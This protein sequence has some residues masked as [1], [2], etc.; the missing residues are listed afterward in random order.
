VNGHIHPLSPPPYV[1][2]DF[3][4]GAPQQ[5]SHK[6]RCSRS[7]ALHLSFGFPNK[8]ALPEA[9]SMEP[10]E[11]AIPHPQSPFIQLSKVPSRR[12][13]L[14]V[15]QK[16]S[17]YE[18]RC[19]SPEPFLNILRGP[20]QRSPSQGFPKNGAPIERDAP[21]VEPPFNYLSEFLVNRHIHPLSPLSL[22]VSG[23]QTYPSS[24]PSSLGLSG[25]PKRSPRTE[26]AHIPELS[27]PLLIYNCLSP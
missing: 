14:Q 15:P 1:L 23:E 5:S 21:S 4:K 3:Q 16:Q 8:G 17:P 13:L 6:E 27:I 22:R 26:D 19:P 25:S 20:Q 10:L 18:E 9:P 7:R 12:V 24:E 11:R 2:L